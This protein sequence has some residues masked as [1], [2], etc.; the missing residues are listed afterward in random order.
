MNNIFNI[1]RSHGGLCISDEVQTGFGRLGKDMWGFKW[2][3]AKPDIITLAKGIGNGYPMGAVVT[4]KEI[5]KSMKRIFN[6][7]AGGPIQCRIG[8]EVL[9]ILRE[10]G[11]P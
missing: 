1:V 6:T 3:K 2:Q 4:R 10:E 5:A 9:K 7:F 8:M 11:L